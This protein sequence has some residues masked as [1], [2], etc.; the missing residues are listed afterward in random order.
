MYEFDDAEG[1]ID[2]SQSH[3]AAGGMEA[4]E[5]KTRWIFLVFNMTL[6]AMVLSFLR[7]DTEP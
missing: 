3:H 4:L 1:K 5:N 7:R 2:F 6:C